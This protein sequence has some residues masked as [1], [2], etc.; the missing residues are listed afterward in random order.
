MA[1][2][3]NL[4]EIDLFSELSDEQVEALSGL[5][6]VEAYEKG[7]KLF[8]VGEEAHDVYILLDGKVSIQVQLSSRPEKVDIVLLGQKGQLI[9]WSGLMG[10]SHYTAAGIC[11]AD[12]K[13]LR[14]NGQE[15]MKVLQEDKEA[16]F[17]VLQK[18]ITVISNRLR[19]LQSVVLKTM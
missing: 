11:Q 12:S 5:A 16:G 17:V 2:D 18:I 7:S 9:G 10:V 14:I 1:E 8:Q 19:N 4:K 6:K 15:F 3:L 13:L